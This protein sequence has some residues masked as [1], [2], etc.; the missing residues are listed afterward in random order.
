MPEAQ[1]SRGV[2]GHA[3]PGNFKIGLAKMQF[4]AFPGPRL[5]SWEGLKGI[6]HAHKNGIFDF[7]I[8]INSLRAV[9]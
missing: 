1:T 9:V 5:V 7:A 2:R 4:P 8:I 3:P 6:K